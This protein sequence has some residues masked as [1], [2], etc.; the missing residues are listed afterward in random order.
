[1]LTKTIKSD[2]SDIDEK[3]NTVVAYISAFGNKDRA[4]DIIV[5]TAFNKT[6]KDRGPQGSDEIWFLADHNKDRVVGKP[7]ELVAD[8]F[9]LKGV[10]KMLNTLAGRDSIEMYKAGVI[11]HHSIGYGVVREERKSDYNELQELRLYEGSHV[12]WPANPMATTQNVDLKALKFDNIQQIEELLK[13]F[14]Y[15]CQN[16]KATDETIQML[17][18]WA[19]KMNQLL[20]EIKST[21]PEDTT[22][23]FSQDVA[24]NLAQFNSLFS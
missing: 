5:K 15:F 21:P 14:Y 4:G 22:E 11:K 2:I 17:S 3:T 10:F 24:D 12:L 18:R 23:P 8:E 6:I 20:S 13:N 16:S 9:G 19:T 1:M 7:T